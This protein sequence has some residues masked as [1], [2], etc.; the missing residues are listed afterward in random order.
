MNPSD[1]YLEFIRRQAAEL[2]A[3]DK[4]PATLDEWETLRAKVR[5]RLQ[6]A[7][8]EFPRD[9]CPL[10]PKVLG[11]LERRGYRVEKVV[12]QTRPDI[13]MT[14]NAYV[15]NV[16]GK[17]PAVLG[18]HG[19]WKGAKQDP[20]VQSRC[21]GLAKLGFFVLAVDAFGAGERGLEPALGEYHGEM[22]GSTLWPTGL[23]LSGLQ[24]YENMRAVDYLQSRPE[25]AGDRIGI[26]GASGGGNQTMYAGAWDKRF[27]CVVP[28]CSV[29]TYQA[30]LGAACCMCEMVPGA[31]V[32]C[33]EWALLASVAPR[34]LMV[35]SA[36]QDAF[37]FSVG[38]AKK[39]IAAADH[40]FKLHNAADK[41]RH[42]VFDW[43]HDYSQQMREAMYGWMTL[44]LK[45][46]GDGSP[47]T[48]PEI[49]PEDPETLRCYPGTTRPKSFV[50]LPQFAAR[51][52]QEIL[53]KRQAP[54]HLEWWQ[55]DSENMRAALRRDVLGTFPDR[56]PLPL[57]IDNSDDGLTRLIKFESEPGVNVSARVSRG[58]SRPRRLAIVLQL[59][60]S[61]AAEQH[62]LTAEFRARG[63]DLVTAE[64]RTTGA[65]AVKNDTI[66]RAIDHNSAQWG[67]WIGR[68]LLGQ[69]VWDVSRLFDSLA[70]LGPGLLRQA[71]VVG[72]GPAGVVA[73]CAAAL[74][75][76]IRQTAVVGTLTSFVSDVPYSGQRVGILA[77][78][79]LKQVGDVPHLAALAVPRSMLIAGGVNG[80]GTNIEGENLSSAYDYTRRVYE[81]LDAGPRL[82][83]LAD[84]SWPQIVSELE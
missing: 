37:Q 2:R 12:F 55:T 18:V 51:E 42:T 79:I 74:D 43:K 40:V 70:Q 28:V 78:G 77:P 38:E 17:V 80:A 29:G 26:T 45:G 83:V 21:I 49:T 48:D 3:N 41:L 63:W 24:V 67:M 5:R 4:P 10:E 20:V 50:T 72:V 57:S 52:G 7:W 31:L 68:P 44:H 69:W 53:R 59:E 33:E 34:A 9:P 39:S 73:M 13:W 19:H 16:R 64:L 71:T 8:G 36:T 1:T 46:Q 25:V 60:G 32:D 22:V 14:A 62:P 81:L 82:K 66:S 76:R 6:S 23:A 84:A 61:E 75:R 30:Y 58:T 56:G 35:I 11:K 27:G 15:P 65:N 47:I 54:D